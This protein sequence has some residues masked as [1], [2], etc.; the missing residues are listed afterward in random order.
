LAAADSRTVSVMP[1][2]RE[3]DL[4]GFRLLWQIS[5]EV[6]FIDFVKFGTAVFAARQIFDPAFGLGQAFLT[7]AR[8]FDAVL[9]KPQALVERKVSALEFS[10]DS[11]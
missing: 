2:E 4:S 10:H 3:F 11:L 5:V 1:P 7:L 9:E 6:V 8:E